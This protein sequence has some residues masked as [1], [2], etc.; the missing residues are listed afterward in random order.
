M[1]IHEI[2][3]AEK[4]YADKLQRIVDETLEQK[5]LIIRI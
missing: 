2:L 4:I 5:E 3:D 1:K